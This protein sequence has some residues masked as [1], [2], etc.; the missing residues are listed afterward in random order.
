VVKRLLKSKRL[1]NLAR[2]GLPTGALTM[3]LF[4]GS[5]SP[6]YAA[7]Q[8]AGRCSLATLNGTYVFANDGFQIV[9]GKPVPF[10]S[11]GQ[12]TYD[13]HGHVKGVFS[14]VTGEL[15]SRQ[16]LYTG[17]YTITPKCLMSLTFTDTT[18]VTSHYDQYVSPDGRVFTFA[19]TDPKFVTSGWEVRVSP[20]TSG[21]PPFKG[22]QP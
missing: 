16:I 7:H 12:E 11:A 9:G 20:R 14:G 1:F 6:S 18:G 17:T 13:G 19:Q 4:L 2:V 22:I 21:A 5:V 10:S 8:T 3:A 15:V